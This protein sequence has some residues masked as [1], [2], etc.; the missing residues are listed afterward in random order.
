MF[1]N[2]FKVALRNLNKYRV[3][4]VIN[5]IGLAIG[6]AAC[7]L[8]LLYI[9]DELTFDQFHPKSD[10]IYRVIDERMSPDLGPRKFGST[11][12][13][14]G[15]ALKNEI[16]EVED[17]ARAAMMG[18]LT[19]ERGDTRV[20]EDFVVVDPALFNI[21]NFEV[22]SGE[23]PAIGM[24]QPFAAV[25]TESMARKYFGD[26]DPI[27]ETLKTSRSFDLKVV[28]VVKDARRNSHLQVDLFVAMA[29]AESDER[30]RPFFQDWDRGG[31]Q[32]YLLLAEGA[33][34]KAVNSKLAGA[35]APHLI[36]ENKEERKLSLQ[37]LSQ[38]HF[39]SGD[40]E[41]ELNEGK[42][43][44]SYVYIL[45]AIALFIVLIACIN[46]MNLATARSMRRAIEVGLRKAVGASRKQLVLQFLSESMLI[47][48]GAFVLSLAAVQNLL[49]AFNRFTGKDLRIGFG[50]EVPLLLVF[51]TLTALVGLIS[52]S[53]PAFYLSS[54]QTI[55]ALRD[56]ARAGTAAR[57]LR[58]GLVVTQFV[59]SFIMVIGTFSAFKQMDYVQNKRLGFNKDKLVVVDINSGAARQAFAAIRDNFLLN[60]QV[61]SVSVTSRVPGEWKNILQLD[62]LPQGANP[63]NTKTMHFFGVDHNFLETFE[64]ELAAGR[65]FDESMTTDTS[66]VLINETAAAVFGWENPVGKRLRFPEEKF[67]A[68]IVGMVKDFHF[69]SLHEKIGP[70]IL[71]HSHNPIH[72]I[73]YFT[74]RIT[75]QNIPETLAYLKRIHEQF[76]PATPFEYHFLD[77]QIENFYRADQQA[78]TLFALS[79]GLAIFIA[80]MGLFGLAA[81]TAE[82]RTKEIGVRKVLGASVA[83]IVVLLCQEFTRLVLVAFA[84]GAPLAFWFMRNWLENFAYHTNLGATTFLR[85]ALL[86]I[87]VAAIT[88]SFQAVKAALVNPV[89]S[90]KYE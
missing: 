81:F 45:A 5:L 90:L 2:Y 41:N 39:H 8:I 83:Q 22:I 17:F 79:G 3:Y 58:K 29:S 10:R 14:V 76:D 44:I 82:Q 55:K 87:A 51:L 67:E 30:A 38:I 34:D 64:V 66:G 16:P 40:I 80:S 57:A 74:A 60:P 59:L 46:Y 19:I 77:Q 75:G 15:P 61:K 42:G 13:P 36:K 12:P 35:L 26:E 27:G 47:T 52:G 72:S 9:H 65:N 33:S 78:T 71:G 4:S 56:Q 25:L 28:S 1:K 69:R 11:A 62:V 84:L 68:H 88:V 37:S 86:V 23:D 54:V 7:M 50:E 70:L 85:A 53:Y 63:E 20:H 21:F 31:I 43:E 89:K 32:T 18:R 6:L 49:P 48:A 73:D 24:Q